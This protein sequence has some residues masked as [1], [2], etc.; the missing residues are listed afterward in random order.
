MCRRRHFILVAGKAVDYRLI[1]IVDDHLDSGAGRR[2]C[3]NVSGGVV[4]GRADV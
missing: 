4:A 2:R 3:V 1:G